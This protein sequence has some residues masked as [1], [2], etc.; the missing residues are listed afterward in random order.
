MRPALK[1][2][3]GIHNLFDRTYYTY[4]NFASLAGLPPQLALR[5]PRSLAPGT[6]RLFYVGVRTYR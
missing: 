5:N 1:L 4:G 3:A 6:P 2:F